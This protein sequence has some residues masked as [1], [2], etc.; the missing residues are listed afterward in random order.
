MSMGKECGTLNIQVDNKLAIA[1]PYI[2]IFSDP[3]P[4]A[5][6]PSN[7]HTVYSNQSMKSN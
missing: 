3:Q 6:N 1:R 5:I 7:Q 2:Y 4:P